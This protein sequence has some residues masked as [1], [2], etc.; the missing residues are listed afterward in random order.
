MCSL[1]LAVVHRSFSRLACPPRLVLILLA[2]GVSFILLTPGVSSCLARHQRLV[3][4][5][6]PRRLVSLA[7]G[8]SSRT[9]PGVSSSSS[10]LFS[11]KQHL[12]QILVLYE[13]YLYRRLGNDQHY[14][15]IPNRCA[16]NRLQNAQTM[17]KSI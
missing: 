5:R 16:R 12:R 4:S 7:H 15:P 14:A 17:L 1:L 9:R 3:T 13:G 8:I 10:S 6:S 11:F 2:P